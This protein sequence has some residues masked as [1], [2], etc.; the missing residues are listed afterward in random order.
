MARSM[1]DPGAPIDL[2]FVE[3]EVYEDAGMSQMKKEGLR[4]TY[5]F[6]QN[7]HRKNVHRMNSHA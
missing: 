7:Q 2:I 5:M 6:R 1:T 3:V 4:Y